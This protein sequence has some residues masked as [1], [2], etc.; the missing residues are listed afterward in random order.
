MLNRWWCTGE[1]RDGYDVVEELAQLPWCNKTV[2]FVGNSW[3]GIIQWFVAA[4]RPP[5][6]ACIAP[7]EGASDI[8]REIICRGGVPCK[9]FLRF[10]AE[11]HFGWLP[12]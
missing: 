11:Q 5:H 3:L 7:L 9:A 1:G 2:A 6:L 12:L 8:Y 4:E 10:L